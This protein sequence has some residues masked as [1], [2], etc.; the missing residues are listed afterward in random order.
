MRLKLSLAATTALTAL[1]LPVAAA[2]VTGLLSDNTL[3]RFDSSAPG[4]TTNVAVTGLAAGETLRGIDYRPK[5]GKLYGVISQADGSGARIV[6]INRIT[7]ATTGVASIKTNAANSIL[8]DGATPVSLRGQ[9]VGV[10]FNPMADALRIVTDQEQ[11]LR[12]N[13]GGRV[14]GGPAGATAIDLDLN[15]GGPPSAGLNI[16]S[17]AYSNNFD[18]A[19]STILYTL[20]TVSDQIF[21]Q[22]PPNNGTQAT[23]VSLNVNAVGHAG[24][25]ILGAIT[26]FASFATDAQGNPAGL[27]AIDLA[28]GMATAL[29]TIGGQLGNLRVTD[30]AVTPIPAALPLLATA[31]G[32][33]G[34][35]ARRRRGA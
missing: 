2:P 14:A 23:P 33:L 17:A 22:N 26:A 30:I 12:A 20:D 9:L 27:Y 29:G 15:L 8:M 28:T 4:T 19:L 1:A 31:L 21:I 34:W 5:D 35:L 13:P 11:N 16:V 6:T 24:F 7:G 18:G 32:G 25:D 10:D 3:L